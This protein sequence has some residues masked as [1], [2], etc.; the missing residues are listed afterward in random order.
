MK[1]F[2][3]NLYMKTPQQF[4]KK[5]SLV[6]FLFFVETKAIQ[7]ENDCCDQACKHAF[8]LNQKLQND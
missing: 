7:A 4:K 3:V 2:Q 6:G 5:T 1:K 8:S